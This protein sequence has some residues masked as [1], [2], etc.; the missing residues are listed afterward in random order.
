[1]ENR[2]QPNVVELETERPACAA[3]EH[4]EKRAEKIG[5]G[6]RK[7]VPRVKSENVPNQFATRVT[8][9]ESGHASNPDQCQCPFHSSSQ[10]R[11]AVGPTS[12]TNQSLY[13]DVCAGEGWDISG[14]P[15]TFGLPKKKM[16]GGLAS[17]HGMS[18]DMDC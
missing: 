7:A 8:L 14:A 10:P 9:E 11:R 12:P 6:S 5:F 4:A 1:M 15:L 16:K 18:R 17:S 13:S 3:H 2:A